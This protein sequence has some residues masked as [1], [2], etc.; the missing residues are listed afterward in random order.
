MSGSDQ[1]SSDV[2]NPAWLDSVLLSLPSAREYCFALSGGLDS[3][4]LL[5]LLVPILR[6][7]GA[8]LRAI[9]VHHGLSP[10][11]DA[12]ADFCLNLCRELNVSCQLHKVQVKPDG[13]GLEAAAR[14]ARYQTF[15]HELRSGEVLL[16]GHHQDDQAETV[17]LRLMRGAAPS[18]LVAIPQSRSLGQGSLFRP[19]L[20]VAR[21]TLL[22]AAEQAGL[23][24]IEDESNQDLALDRNYLRHAV[25]PVLA[26]RWPQARAALARV[27]LQARQQAQLLDQLLAP[28]LATALRMTPFGPVLRLD[29]LRSLSDLHRNALIR[30]WLES[31]SVPQ[32]PAAILQRL[33]REVLAARADASPELRWGQHTLRVYRGDLFYVTAAET[34]NQSHLFAQTDLPLSVELNG[35]RV[36]LAESEGCPDTDASALAAVLAVL[37]DEGFFELRGKRQNDALRLHSGQHQAMQRV[38]Q[39]LG[40]PPWWRASWPMLFVGDV[41]ICA[42]P[43]KVDPAYR[44]DSGFQIDE[45]KVIRKGDKNRDENNDG[46]CSPLRRLIIRWSRKSMPQ[47]LV[48]F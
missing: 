24:W 48:K 40:I 3:V 26:E 8:V 36:E 32:I 2:T 35:W 44:H 30:R 9:H 6:A 18:E 10:N 27:A 19:W 16:Q 11:A 4:S 34:S 13:A 46:K 33:E 12:W 38:C 39:D 21:Q 14:Q 15:E 47:S 28:S 1:P 20:G 45:A 22:T 29:A 37:P 17:L 31:I 25:L 5:S 23:R 43:G 7:R 41:L 42:G